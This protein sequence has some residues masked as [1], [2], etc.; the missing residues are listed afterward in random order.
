MLEGTGGCLYETNAFQLSNADELPKPVSA[1]HIP[2]ASGN[3]MKIPKLSV[4]GRGINLSEE[5]NKSGLWKQ[6]ASESSFGS[7]EGLESR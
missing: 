4:I 5:V 7:K 6:I 3:V 2:L 1:F